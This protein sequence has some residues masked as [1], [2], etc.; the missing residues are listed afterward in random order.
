MFRLSHKLVVQ[1]W[2]NWRVHSTTF[3]S[4]IFRTYRNTPSKKCTPARR[5]ILT[6]CCLQL[7]HQRACG[8]LR[9]NSHSTFFSYRS[10]T[11]NAITTEIARKISPR[12]SGSVSGYLSSYNGKHKKE[13]ELERLEELKARMQAITIRILSQGKRSI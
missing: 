8:N 3:F 2:Q 11:D 7:I 12:A 4:L 10:T 13:F 6:P 9:L 1:H 5:K